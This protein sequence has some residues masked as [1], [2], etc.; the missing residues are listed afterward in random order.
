MKVRIINRQKI[1][2]I[3]LKSFNQYLKKARTYL[4][5]SSQRLSILFCDNRFIKKLNQKY[6][7]KAEATD[8]IAFP[9]CDELEPD[10]LGDIIVSV[11]EA[12]KTARKIK[13]RWQDELFLYCLHGILHLLGY[14]DRNQAQRKRMEQKQLQIM[15][16]VLNRKQWGRFFRSADPG[17]Q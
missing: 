10:Y 3:N 9:L 17:G 1:K 6:F 7:A 13:V 4:N 15:G 14:D 5:I 12:V 11:E 16:T 2:R 8:V